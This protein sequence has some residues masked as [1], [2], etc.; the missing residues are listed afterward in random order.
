MSIGHNV[1]ESYLHVVS[2]VVITTLPKQSVGYDVVDIKFVKHRV[3]IL[4][5]ADR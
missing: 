1:E 4:E 5:I 3:R 2:F